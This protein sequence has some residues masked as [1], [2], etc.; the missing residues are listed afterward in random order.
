MQTLCNQEEE[1]QKEVRG[2]DLTI[3][4]MRRMKGGEIE[5]VMAFTLPN[6]R[7]E[8]G[9]LSRKAK[10]CIQLALDYIEK[11]PETHYMTVGYGHA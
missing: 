5:D 9:N 4:V 3:R 6:H 7:T 11:F 8:E 1:K 2:M 10:E